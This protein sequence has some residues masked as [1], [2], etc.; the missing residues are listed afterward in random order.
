MAITL[1]KGRPGA[2]KSYEC[3]VNHIL[4]SLKEG[5]KVVTNI[6]LNVDHFAKVIGPHVKDLLVVQKFSFDNAA[7]S[8][9]ELFERYNDIRDKQID[10]GH[11]DPLPELTEQD[12]SMD[13]PNLAEPVDYV[14]YMDWKN[15]KNQG[16][17]FVIDECHFHFPLSGRGKNKS[18]LED[19]QVKFFS[20]H[21]H[22][23]FD[24]IFLTQSDKKINRMMRE[25]IE[26]CIEVRK[27]RAVGD[28]SY[29]RFMYYY[30]E[31]KRSGLID[32]S[33]RKY[34]KRYFPF[35]KSHTKSDGE[36][37]EAS[38]KD[39]KKWHQHWGIRIPFVLVIVGVIS[40]ANALSGI[41]GDKEAKQVE[42]VHQKT[43]VIDS[44][45]PA[46]KRKT[47]PKQQSFN[48]LPY[49]SFDIFITGHSDSSYTDSNGVFHSRKQV[50]F[51]AIN[52]AKYEIQLRLDDLY[53]A[54]YTVSVYSPCL[55]RL[56]YQERT[57]LIYCKGKVPSS[58]PAKSI[59]D[60]ASL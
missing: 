19:R 60:V 13:A 20:G 6:P 58:S 45:K 59:T 14:S 55:V 26:I 16:A 15:D 39:M 8:R 49:G 22:Y 2:G 21:R 37:Q 53:L 57:K 40:S 42:P 47:L 27:N 29:I 46:P 4:P 36:I 56:T 31:T 34:E 12:I 28:K 32:Q 44:E 48:D 23:G 10:D 11:E 41:F 54:G 7:G 3:V 43:Q 30:G 33:Q 50:Y 1:I 25:D 51:D 52:N 9:S 38:V 35:Y 18:Q 17:L 24:F 5:R